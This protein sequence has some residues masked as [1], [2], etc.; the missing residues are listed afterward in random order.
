MTKR[1]PKPQTG[2]V[3]RVIKADPIV[4]PREMVDLNKVIFAA[5]WGGF[6]YVV[7]DSSGEYYRVTD[8]PFGKRVVWEDSR[9]LS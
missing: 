8:R 6:R 4:D 2:I 5:K 9:G 7:L 3:P 1:I